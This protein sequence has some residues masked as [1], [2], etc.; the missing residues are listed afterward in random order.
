MISIY[1]LNRAID[2]ACKEGTHQMLWIAVAAW[3]P[4]PQRRL[5]SEAS[6]HED[7]LAG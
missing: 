7:D 5:K 4:H 3:A 2:E 6:A 1:K